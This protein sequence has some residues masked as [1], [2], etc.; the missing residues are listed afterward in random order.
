MGG[1]IELDSQNGWTLFTLVLS[2]DAG[3]EGTG[4]GR[5]GSSRFAHVKTVARFHVRSLAARAA[6]RGLSCTGRLQWPPVR[7]GSAASLALIAAVLGG[8]AVLVVAKA[9]GWLGETT[10]KTVVVRQATA[11]SGI[12]GPVVAAKPIVGNGFQPAQIYRSRARP[13]S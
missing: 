6:F 8:V 1:R 5:V 9:T 4:R 13:G 12:G 2:A 10:T 11:A 7:T 3:A